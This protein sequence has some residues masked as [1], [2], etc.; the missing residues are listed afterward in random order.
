MGNGTIAVSE[1]NGYAISYEPR[2]SIYNPPNRG[3]YKQSYAKF[4]SR[5]KSDLFVTGGRA[6]GKENRRGRR[7]PGKSLI[8]DP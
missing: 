6:K 4:H 2:Y 7:E 1:A 8:G 3:A 5:V